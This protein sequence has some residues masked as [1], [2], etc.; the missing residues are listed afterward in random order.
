MFFKLF[1]ANRATNTVL[2]Y[3]AEHRS[4]KLCI[5]PAFGLILLPVIKQIPYCTNYYSL[6]C[7]SFFYLKVVCVKNCEFSSSQSFFYSVRYFMAC[8][9][10]PYK[11]SKTKD[12]VSVY[13]DSTL[14][15]R[16]IIYVCGV[17][18]VCIY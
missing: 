7:H 8:V 16:E 18:V 4:I 14:L 15:E 10:F 11:R 2:D 5:L 12:W 3:P 1:F 9:L 13:F 6:L 17:G